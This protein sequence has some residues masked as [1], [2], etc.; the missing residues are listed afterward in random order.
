MI[1]ALLLIALL[2]AETAQAPSAPA[3]ASTAPASNAGEAPSEY[4]VGAGDVLDI[5][6]LDNAELS[7]IAVVQTN[8]NLSLPLLG[9]VPVSTLTVPEIK[10][11]ITSQLAAYVL[12]P[13]VEVKV[14]DY[15]S[16][17][18]T[19]IGEVNRPGRKPLRDRTRLLDVLLEAGGFTPGASGEVTISRRDGSFAGGERTLRIRLGRTQL[20]VQ[21]QANLE[22]PLRNGDFV[23]ASPKYYVTVEGEVARPNRYVIEPDLT[24][25][26]AI[27]LAGGLTRY[28]SHKVKVRRTHPTDGTTEILKVDLKEIRKGEEPDLRVQANDVVTVDRGLF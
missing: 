12:N 26:G 23:T 17:F 7:R 5:V 13:Q 1:L 20:T 24:V 11:K 3:A 2:A 27:S 10:A 8:G 16:Q 15:Q 22:V 19:V 14:K 21:D 18:V 25:S 4:R 6:V 9:E 28:G